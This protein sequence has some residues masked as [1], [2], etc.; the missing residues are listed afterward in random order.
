MS[1]KR[2]FHSKIEMVF[3]TL[4]EDIVFGLLREGKKIVA[5]EVATERK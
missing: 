3:E 1:T 5:R 2:S 4:K